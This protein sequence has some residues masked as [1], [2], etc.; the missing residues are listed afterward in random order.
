MNNPQQSYTLPD[1]EGRGGAIVF[2]T[3]NKHKLSEIR[4]ILGDRFECS[5]SKTSTATQTSPKQPTRLRATPF[6]R[7]AT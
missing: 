2:A 3:N 1:G 7:H 4:A 6:R 5:R